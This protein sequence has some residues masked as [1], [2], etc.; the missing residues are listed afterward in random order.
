MAKMVKN[1]SGSAF[2]WKS[3]M[4]MTMSYPSEALLFLT[5]TL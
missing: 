2:S 5:T 1:T 4:K 3:M